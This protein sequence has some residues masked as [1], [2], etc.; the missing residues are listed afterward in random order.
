MH[1]DEPEAPSWLMPGNGADMPEPG[2]SHDAWAEYA[3]GRGMPA[4]LAASLTKDQ[5]RITF[6]PRGIASLSGPPRLQLHERD[7]ATVAVQRRASAK[8]WERV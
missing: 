4:E 2:A 5:I 8:P 7:P 1:Q 3:T 6:D